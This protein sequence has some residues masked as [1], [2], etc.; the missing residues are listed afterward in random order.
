MI[1]EGRVSVNGNVVRNPSRRCSPADD[2]FAVDGLK[3]APKRLVYILMNKPE[4][5]VTTRSDERKRATVYDVLGEM[6]SWLFPVGRLDKDT[7]GLLLLTNDNQLGEK[8]TSPRSR[9]PKTYR[10]R[11]DR[12]IGDADLGKLRKGITLRGTKLLPAVVSR[13]DGT[14]F[15]MTIVEGKNRQIRRMCEQL[16]FNVLALMRVKIGEC[17]L[18]GLKPGEWRYVT[19]RE[20]QLLLP[21]AAGRR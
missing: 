4:G 7:S 9:V 6:G 11:L 12:K 21:V 17:D 18:G 19:K 2:R 14:S 5:V 3:L 13:E 15:E 20:V 8:L 10:V 16:G 1:R